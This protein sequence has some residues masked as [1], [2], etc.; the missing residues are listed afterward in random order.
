MLLKPR[1]TEEDTVRRKKSVSPSP[2]R[3]AKIMADGGIFMQI[4]DVQYQEEKLK[5]IKTTLEERTVQK[6]VLQSDSV[7]KL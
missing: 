1:F 4:C 2:E 5:S 7:F 3:G 6:R